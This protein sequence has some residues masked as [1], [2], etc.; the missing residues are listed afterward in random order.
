MT[1]SEIVMICHENVHAQYLP[2]PRILYQRYQQISP[3]R[4]L[5]SLAP[6]TIR[7][8]AGKNMSEKD[9]H[10]PQADH[11]NGRE[12]TVKAHLDILIRLSHP[13]RGGTHGL[14]NGNRRETLG[15]NG[16]SPVP[17]KEVDDVIRLCV[18]A[19]GIDRRVKVRKEAEFCGDDDRR[20][21]RHYAG[22]HR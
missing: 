19:E 21:P 18:A 11:D 4:S 2:I 16:E 22:R 1:T 20:H 15:E 7:M 10:Y 9:H 5:Q 12:D 8:M 3:V 6:D 17:M 13:W 14:G